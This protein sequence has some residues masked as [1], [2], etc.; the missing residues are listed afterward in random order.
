[1]LRQQ[2]NN[3]S[4]AT[5]KAVLLT[6]YRIGFPTSDTRSRPTQHSSYVIKLH[7]AAGKTIHGNSVFIKL[8][9]VITKTFK[10]VKPRRIRVYQIL[11]T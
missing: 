10:Q 2:C 1:M 11:N 5:A 3:V 4:P 6:V 9:N 7:A 8:H